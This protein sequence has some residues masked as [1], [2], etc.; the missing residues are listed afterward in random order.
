MLARLVEHHGRRSFGNLLK[1]HRHP[2]F[3]LAAAI[4]LGASR[5]Y[6]YRL[7]AARGVFDPSALDG[8]A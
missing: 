3:G 6:G 7:D 4:L 1:G 5:A 8:A 2:G